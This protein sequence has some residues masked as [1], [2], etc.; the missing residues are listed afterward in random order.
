MCCWAA[1]GE[2]KA[3]WKM[4]KQSQFLISGLVSL[5]WV[6]E[7]RKSRDD[8]RLSRLDSLRHRDRH[9]DRDRDRDR[10]RGRGIDR[11]SRL[12]IAIMRRTIMRRLSLGL[13]CLPGLCRSDGCLAP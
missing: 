5:L 13:R 7:E 1:A 10:D 12:G 6:V 9:T 2:I 8:S 4:K 11:E 3:N